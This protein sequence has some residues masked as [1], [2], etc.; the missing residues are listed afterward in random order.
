MNLKDLAPHT[1]E[2]QMMA[3]LAGSFTLLLAVM[4]VFE[5]L[6]YDS[7]T[8]WAR[9]EPTLNRLNRI[10]PIVESISEDQVT[11]FLMQ[12]SHCHEGYVVSDAPYAFDRVTE[13]TQFIAAW[14]EKSLKMGPASVKAGF[15]ALDQNDFAYSEC[16]ATEMNFPV[17]GIVI[18]LRLTS[19]AWL[20]A[21]IHPHEW[22]VTPSMTDW[23]LRTGA[24]FLIIGA[25]ALLFVRRLSKPINALT[26][27]A[28]RFGAGLE[29]K[30]VDEMGPPDVRHTI[31]SFN[32]MQRQ[33]SDELQRRTSALAA[34]SHD[35]RSP[36]TALRIKAELIEDED[37][38]RD[39]I[40]SVDKMER[41][42]ASAL[43]FLK[44]ESRSEL[45]RQVD[46][47]ALVD[48]ECADFR[49]VGATVSFDCPKTI[50]YACRPDALA[51]AVNNLI[52]NAI[53]YAGSASVTVKQQ[54][55]YIEI[56]V[57]DCGPGI[58]AD[59]MADVL[60]PFER[61][62][63]ARESDTGGFGLGLA[64]AKAVTEGHDGVFEL[65]ANKPRGLVATIRL[66]V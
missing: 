58:P 33:V 57:S 5:F 15:S 42:T 1:I 46:L 51:R 56:A 34:I 35:I 54:S 17:D 61:L 43:A 32:A 55:D 19:G 39:L 44:G 37:T 53:K 62:S 38:R 24:A 10:V 20:N 12:S 40:A 59:K 6:E 22:H 13:E 18:S 45:K 63:E 23:L 26:R 16:E 31:R 14:I 41:I 52:E 21:E 7:V 9:S 3:V 11:G 4:A 8:E 66:P 2:T 36:L 65:T 50:Q 47:G 27:G 30:L 28:Q 29:V 48:S 60:K 64:I 25:A 49:E